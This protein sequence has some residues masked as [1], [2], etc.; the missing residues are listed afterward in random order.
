MTGFYILD[1]S[2]KFSEHFSI[3]SCK[4]VKN[5]LSYSSINSPMIT[6]DVTTHQLV[7]TGTQ[8]LEIGHFGQPVSAK[9][10]LRSQFFIILG[11]NLVG[12]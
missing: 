7:T 1:N 2:P 5:S 6:S 11:Q 12:A 10:V 4:S 9:Q 3:F 8:N